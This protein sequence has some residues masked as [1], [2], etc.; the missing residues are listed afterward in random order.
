[1]KTSK[2]NYTFFLFCRIAEIQH[3]KLPLE[4]DA[5]FI[6]LEKLFNQYQSSTY[7]DSYKNEFECMMQFFEEVVHAKKSATA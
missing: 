4:I 1:M 2:Q 6:E 5:E 3:V 7:N